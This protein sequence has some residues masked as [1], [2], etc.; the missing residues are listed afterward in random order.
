[1][2]ITL[3]WSPMQDLVDR[4]YYDEEP[5]RYIE[6]AD[7]HVKSQAASWRKFAKSEAWRSVEAALIMDARRR[8]AGLLKGEGDMEIHRAMAQFS[9]YIISIPKRI[10][11][12][13]E[14]Y[15]SSSM[16]SLEG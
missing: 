7:G 8:L 4:L 3:D 11:Q 13:E 9:E 10:E 1:M 12:L 15:E 6:D 14:Q 2:T 16:R 5:V